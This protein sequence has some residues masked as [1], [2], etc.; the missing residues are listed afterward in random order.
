MER[1]KIIFCS[2][3]NSS[4]E[5]ELEAFYNANNNL[6]L[7]IKDPKDESGYYDMFIELDKITAV[8]FV[9]HI[10]KEI[11]FMGSEVNNG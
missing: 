4:A 5:H 9:K 8:K 7:R 3:E 10:K 1:T 6:T 2:A 11:S